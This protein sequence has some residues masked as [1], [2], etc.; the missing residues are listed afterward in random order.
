MPTIDEILDYYDTHEDD[1]PEA[2][3]DIADQIFDVTDDDDVPQEYYLWI[4][5]QLMLLHKGGQL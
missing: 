3:F 2:I 5:R 4:G 1:I